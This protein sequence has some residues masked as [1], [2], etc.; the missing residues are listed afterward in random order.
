MATF[1]TV[2]KRFSKNGDEFDLSAVVVEDEDGSGI[3]P[4]N[5]D[6]ALSSLFDIAKM[7]GA[8]P[9]SEAGQGQNR[10]TGG[11]SPFSRSSGNNS[12][13]SNRPQGGGN[14]PQ[15]GNNSHQGG[16]NRPQGNNRPQ[17]GGNQ[18]SGGENE[19][20]QADAV[21]VRLKTVYSPKKKTEYIVADWFVEPYK[22]RDGSYGGLKSVA[23]QFL[24]SSKDREIFQNATGINLNDA[25]LGPQEATK[26]RDLDVEE[27]FDYF[28]DNPVTIA[29]TVT[30]N[31]VGNGRVYKEG[32]FKNYVWDN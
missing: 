16:G 20:Q 22:L 23:T 19:V 15:G 13:G 8:S 6:Q 17:G 2:G 1:Y 4:A 32:K 9:V 27:P 3:S 21:M 10:N 29:Y 24:A 30:M 14:R 7:M 12:G 25:N 28:F 31:D 11:G 26:Y 5:I 18:N